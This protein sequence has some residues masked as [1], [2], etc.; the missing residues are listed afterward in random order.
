MILKLEKFYNRRKI[1]RWEKVDGKQI[2]SKSNEN[3]GIIAEKDNPQPE[4]DEQNKNKKDPEN[5]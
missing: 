5:D 4:N 2:K 3:S 1:R